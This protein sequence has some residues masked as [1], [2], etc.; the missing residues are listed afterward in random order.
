[1]LPRTRTCRDLPRYSNFSAN[2]SQDI[3]TCRSFALSYYCCF[4]PDR[5]EKASLSRKYAMLFIRSCTTLSNRHSFR[6]LLS[7]VTKRHLTLDTLN[8]RIITKVLDEYVIG[9]ERAKKTLSVAVYNHYTRVQ[10]NM[11]RAQA[12]RKREEAAGGGNRQPSST[13]ATGVDDDHPHIFHHHEQEE[14]PSPVVIGDQEEKEQQDLLSSS[15]SAAAA[16]A[17]SMAENEMDTT[18]LEKSNVL[19][20]GPTG[21]GKTLLAKTL[22]NILQVPF[23]M[24]DA[25]SFTQAGYVGDDVESVIERLLQSCDYDIDKAETGIVFIDEI[26]KLART[27]GPEGTRSSSRD[28][29]GEG[30]QQALLRML[31]GT[32]VKVTNKGV[33]TSSN[34]SGGTYM[35]QPVNPPSASSSSSSS[36]LKTAPGGGPG[37]SYNVDTSNI[38]FILSGAFVGLE[39]HIKQR[40]NKASSTGFGEGIITTTTAY[41]TTLDHVEPH[42]IMKFGFLPEFVGRLPVVASV[43]QLSEDDLVRVLTE[44]KNALVKQYQDLFHLYQAEIRFT[45]QALSII[46][47]HAV[48]KQTGARGLRRIM[49]NLLLDAMYDTPGSSIRHILV[50]EDAVSEKGKPL[51]Y[52]RGQWSFM[53]YKLEQENNGNENT[54]KIISRE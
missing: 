23:S 53:E 33:P 12:A 10:A 9:Q 29:G 50:N 28:V 5:K 36:A 43:N 49:E 42:D 21:S 47:R 15:S 8:P 14:E 20:I 16:A 19:L 26:D 18:L 38:L 7:P 46:A 40:L 34:L 37:D 31:E 45:N 3:K 44:P 17:N 35:G 25:T 24:S 32:T 27:G 41:K 1:M 39:E 4:A 48:Q 6:V 2:F 51:Y 30:V 22:A 52:P 11:A 13:V 54:R